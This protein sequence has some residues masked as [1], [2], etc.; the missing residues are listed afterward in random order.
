LLRPI[1]EGSAQVPEDDDLHRMPVMNMPDPWLA[2]QPY[3]YF[4]GR[5]SRLIA[6]AFIEWLSPSPALRWLD[7]GCGTGAL[8]QTILT[9]ASPAS[10]L[11]VDPADA[12]IAFAKHTMTDARITFQVGDALNLPADAHDL[13]MAVSGL[14][15]NFI[16]EPVTAL[17]ALRQGLQPDGMIALYV[18]DYGGKMEMLRHFWDSVVT[19]DPDART[20]DEGVRFPICQ[21]DALSEVFVEAG[22]KHVEVEGLEAIMTFSDFDDY[23][24]PFL[25]GQGPA[26]GYVAGLDATGRARLEKH[27]YAALP[28]REDGS[29]NLVARVW[30]V[31][32]TV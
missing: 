1:A 2:G 23:W 3:E 30:A 16:P 17:R 27:L 5:W 31:R 11:A 22:L 9:L 18:W 6:R 10:I 26:P 25:G 15:L 29:L 21:P 4:M 24:S 12:F 7:L 32:A 13:Q 8:S 20:L 28:I 19:L 14:V